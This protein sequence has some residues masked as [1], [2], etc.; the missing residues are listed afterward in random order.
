MG[1]L[2]QVRDVSEDTHRKLKARAA[3]AGQSL[4]EFI[5]HELDKVAVRPTQE[6]V[7]K[8][9][10]SRTPVRLTKAPSE[11]LSEMREDS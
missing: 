4:S 9:V 1:V 5:R 10:R 11:I 6:E 7:L 8:R 3:E 2:V